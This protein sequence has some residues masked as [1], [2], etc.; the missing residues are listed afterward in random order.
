MVLVN[1]IVE[2]S[3]K[4]LG[5][6]PLVTEKKIFSFTFEWQKTIK[7]LI[8]LEKSLNPFESINF[9]TILENIP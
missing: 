8:K 9:K 4:I 7:I 3:N 5:I 6:T 1:A 2:T